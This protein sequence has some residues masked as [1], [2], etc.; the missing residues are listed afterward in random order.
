MSSTTDGERVARFFTSARNVSIR[1]G[2][3]PGGGRIPGGPYTITQIL[4]GSATLVVGWWS[5]PFWG[6]S[7]GSFIVQLATLAIAAVGATWLSGRIPST[8]RKIPSLTLDAFSAVTAS[9]YGT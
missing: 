9:S 8:R 2:K 4:I 6:P 5:R 3:W 1:L 7:V